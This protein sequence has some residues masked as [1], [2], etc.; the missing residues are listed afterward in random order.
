MAFNGTVTVTTSGQSVA[1][2]TGQNDQF[3]A[4]S[5]YFYTTAGG[6]S[7]WLDITTT[8]GNTGS[9]GFSV[10]A[11]TLLPFTNLSGITGFSAI[12]STAGGSLTVSYLASR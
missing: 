7:F 10:P 11:N 1:F 8:S 3:R 12:A 9:T 4:R 5:L 2:S 6:G